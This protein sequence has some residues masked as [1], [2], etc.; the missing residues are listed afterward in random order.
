M[1]I[2]VISENFTNGGLER[3][4]SNQY[5]TLKDKVNFVYAFSHYEENGFLS[6]SKKYFLKNDTTL[7]TL[8]DNTNLLTK[9]IKENKI[10]VIHVHPFLTLFPAMFA[11]QLTNT[12]IAYTIHGFGSINWFSNLNDEILFRYFL[13]E[14]D[15]LV[16]SV[17]DKYTKY[18]QNKFLVS[19]IRYLPNGMDTEKFKDIKCVKN[20]KWLLISRLDNDKKREIIKVFENL[21]NL[22]IELDIVGDGESTSELKKLAEDLQIKD[23][24]TFKGYQTDIPE[25][26]KQGYNGV[27]GIGQ[28]VLEGLLSN[29]PVLL[30]GFGRIT[31]MID[32]NLYEKI[33]VNNFVNRFVKDEFDLKAFLNVNKN[34]KKYQLR[35]I[36]KEEFDVNKI[37][38]EYYQVLKKINFVNSD[39]LKDVF[40]E[41][42]IRLKNDDIKK[43]N[44][45]TSNTFFEI[46][47]NNLKKYIVDPDLLNLFYKKELLDTEELIKKQDE[48]IE[49]LE[50]AINNIG[51]RTV[52][53]RTTTSIKNK[54]KK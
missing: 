25:Q 53:K 48:K 16:I 23:K 3:H 35:D 51:L 52:V 9:I 11:S 8:Y 21:K 1:N 31:G 14:L 7:Q 45:V 46:I 43:E 27:I 41:L 34:L 33:K 49:K 42:E 5:N 36:V 20:N 24:V 2:L 6:H 4:I 26:L 54:L 18:L 29:L 47:R 37:Y 28:V 10:D 19:N 50:F 44:F 39:S 38:E 40:K 32:K 30:I 15:P 13:S 12:P 22:N 17:S